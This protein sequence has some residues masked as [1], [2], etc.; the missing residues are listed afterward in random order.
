MYLAQIGLFV[1]AVLVGIVLG[2]IFTCCEL[3]MIC[4]CGNPEK[5]E[6][7]KKKF[8]YRKHVNYCY[9]IIQLPFLIGVSLFA[10]IILYS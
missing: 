5:R 2:V 3:Y 8:K 10:F 1:I 9:K 6:S 4:K 7:L